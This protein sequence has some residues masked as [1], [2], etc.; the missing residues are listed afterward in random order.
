MSIPARTADSASL[1]AG[2]RALASALLEP[3]GRYARAF[4]TLI[5]ALIMLSVATVGLEA[6]PGLP[7]WAW[8]ILYWGEVVVVAVFSFEYLLRIAS[9]REKLKF[10]FSFHGLVD[11]LA[12][13]PFYLSGFDTQWLRALRLLRVLKLQTHVLEYNV[14]TRTHEL[15]ES[16]ASLEREQ[17]RI[18]AELD[19]AR[20][21]QIAI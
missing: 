6:I 8:H 19:V 9:S 15:A 10:I 14:A 12:I 4:E 17:A 5:L 2:V 21:L 20:A 16:N 18:K 11:L 3:G 7:A 13:V 1:P